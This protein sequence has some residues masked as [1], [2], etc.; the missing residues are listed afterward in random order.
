MDCKKKKEKERKKKRNRWYVV[1]IRALGTFGIQS[2]NKSP[3]LQDTP[4]T[5]V[6]PTFRNRPRWAGRY[7]A[8][9][10]S[11]RSWAVSVL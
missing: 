8:H 4:T 2:Q 6:G 1:C 9:E 5:T 3:S 11:T 10:K 7:F